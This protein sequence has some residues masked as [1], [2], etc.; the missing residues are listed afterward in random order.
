MDAGLQRATG[1]GFAAAGLP[2]GAGEG[3]LMRKK[4]TSWT[5][6]GASE[7]SKNGGVGAS[8]FT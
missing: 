4:T 6:P 1:W 5:A 8:I 2:A 3:L 7:S